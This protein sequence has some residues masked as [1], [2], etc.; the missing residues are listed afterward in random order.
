MH[1][2][3]RTSLSPIEPADKPAHR[4]AIA[5]SIIPTDAGKI[6][7]IDSREKRRAAK[8]RGTNLRH[9]EHR[10]TTIV[11]SESGTRKFDKQ[12][13]LMKAWPNIWE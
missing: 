2:L 4:E 7:D 6:K 10:C 8:K 1:D 9:L 12:V 13:P 5:H 11:I 3:R